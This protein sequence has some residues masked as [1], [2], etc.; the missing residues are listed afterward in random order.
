M[1]EEAAAAARAVAAALGL[2]RN[3]GTTGLAA[4]LARAV[5]ALPAWARWRIARDT[6]AV[7]TGVRVLASFDGA[8]VPDAEALARCLG[9]A[10]AVAAAAAAGEPGAA[11][12]GGGGALLSA[13][14]LLVVDGVCC[15]CAPA[16]LLRDCAAR[17]EALKREDGREEEE[18]EEAEEEDEDNARAGGGLRAPPAPAP[19]PPP[20]PPQPRAPLLVCLD[21]DAPR[22]A[23]PDVRARVCAQLEGLQ[24]ALDLAFRRHCAPPA[25]ANGADA[26]AAPDAA[27]ALPVVPDVLLPPASSSSPPPLLPALPTL[28][29]WLLGYPVVYVVGQ[30]EEEDAGRRAAASLQ[31]ASASSARGGGGGLSLVRAVLPCCHDCL[32]AE[33]PGPLG[34]SHDPLWQFSVPAQAVGGERAVARL[35]QRAER[36]LRARVAAA[37]AGSWS[38]P[39]RVEL[40][41]ASWGPAIVL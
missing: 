34:A 36:E 3:D 23:P 22:L 4:P 2:R 28:N 26:N 40:A 10:A 32:P 1:S 35:A 5:R 25:A 16:R 9:P 30:G 37:A 6:L 13:L 38:G 39:P 14:A 33:P 31:H 7:A 24:S 19:P 15:V 29:G 20:P 41:P 8:H 12:G 27:A 21:G 18:E 11:G 17:L